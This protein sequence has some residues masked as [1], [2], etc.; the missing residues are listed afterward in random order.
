[1]RNIETDR[2]LTHL[3]FKSVIALITGVCEVSKDFPQKAMEA[4]LILQL[5]SK[6]LQ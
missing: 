4:G 5:F 1:M 3:Y 6:G 2:A